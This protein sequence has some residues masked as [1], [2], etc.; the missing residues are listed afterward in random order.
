MAT[1]GRIPFSIENFYHQLVKVVVSNDLVREIICIA[2]ASSLCSKSINLIENRDFRA[3]LLMLRET[4]KDQEIPHRTKLRSLII[5]YWLEYWEDL[6][7]AL[8]VS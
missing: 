5:E 6:K 4:L 8:A 1:E 3:L 2:V 7:A